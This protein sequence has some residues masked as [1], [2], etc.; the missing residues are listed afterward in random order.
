MTSEPGG[1]LYEGERKKAQGWRVGV[2]T[3]HGVGQVEG[4]GG[5]LFPSGWE[6]VRKLERSHRTSEGTCGQP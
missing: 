1:W 6:V 3:R 5:R 2:D 4:C